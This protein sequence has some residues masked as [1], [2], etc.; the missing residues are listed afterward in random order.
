MGVYS[1]LR[2]YVRWEYSAFCISLSKYILSPLAFLSILWYIA[3]MSNQEK[4]SQKVEA[5]Q[6]LFSIIRVML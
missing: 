6:A 2:G 3:C 4:Q 1:L 5:S